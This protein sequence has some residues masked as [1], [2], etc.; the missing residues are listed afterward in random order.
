MKT[1][2]VLG[3][4]DGENGSDHY[5]LNRATGEIHVFRYD[6]LNYLMRLYV[7]RPTSQQHFQ[8]QVGA[9]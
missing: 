2:H 8:R 3:F 1:G 9:R 4:D 6:G 7:V 5:I